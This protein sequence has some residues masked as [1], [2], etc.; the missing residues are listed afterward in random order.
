[1][2]VPRIIFEL[3]R[4]EGKG[5][6]LIQ[7]R[8]DSGTG[9]ACIVTGEIIDISPRAS[10]NVPVVSYQVVPFIL[11]VYTI[12]ALRLGIPCVMGEQISCII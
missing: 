11:S 1:M 3:N 4:F 5:A 12:I 6:N 8:F 9:Y 10:L 7:S 2:D